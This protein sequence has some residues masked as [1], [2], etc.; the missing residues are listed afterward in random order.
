MAYNFRSI[1]L[2]SL[3]VDSVSRS[4]IVQH[5]LP[6]LVLGSSV[7]SSVLLK[8][9]CEPLIESIKSDG[10]SLLKVAGCLVGAAVAAK[11]IGLV[12]KVGWKAWQAKRRRGRNLDTSYIVQL[13]RRVQERLSEEANAQVSDESYESVDMGDLQA[14]PVELIGTVMVGGVPVA[15][16][17]AVERPVPEQLVEAHRVRVR[18]RKAPFLAKIT[19]LAKNHFGGCPESTKS[20]VMA[21]SKFVYDQCKEHNCLPHQTRLIISVVV[22]LV[23][24]PDQYDLSSRALLN[25]PSVCENRSLDE[26][27]KSIDDWLSNLICHPLDSRAWRRAMDVLAGLPDWKAFRIV[28]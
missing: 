14:H 12:G 28:H 10:V 13:G 5:A 15:L 18:H 11:A 17:E 27:Y 16:P 4:R 20:N 21:V 19:N 22:P 6:S 9:Q 24:S 2:H 3:V 8:S 26:S 1:G 23:L 7:P 25:S